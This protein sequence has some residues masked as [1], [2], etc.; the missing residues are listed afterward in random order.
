MIH[1]TITNTTFESRI[2]YGT[3]D[4]NVNT[5][6]SYSNNEDSGRDTSKD[7]EPTLGGGDV[8]I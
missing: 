4:I 2:T 5:S 1:I 6:S 8:E 7:S 3:T